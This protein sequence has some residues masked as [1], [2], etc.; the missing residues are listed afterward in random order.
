M[1]IIP[2]HNLACPLDGLPL[3]LKE[4]QLSCDNGHCFDVARQGYTNLLAVQDKRSKHPGDTKEMVDARTKFL[5]TD[6]YKPISDH[7]NALV[8]KD[9][10]GRAQ[11]EAES[12]SILDAGCGEG[13]YLENLRAGLQER[14]GLTECSLIGMDISKPAVQACCKRNKADISWV[15]GTNR[16]PPVLENSLDLIICMFGYPVFDVFKKYLK[17]NGAVILVDT[18]RDHLI[19]LREMIYD[20]VRYNDVTMPKAA[21][22]EGYALA[23]R[24]NIRTQIDKLPSQQIFDL[25]AMTPHYFR[26]KNEHRASLEA[27]SQMDITI[28]VTFQILKVSK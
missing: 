6:A 5:N 1:K 16:K 23:E 3:T 13:Y 20:D 24:S 18:D 25:L 26:M 19:E 10:E 22:A 4:R 17:P 28:D 8:Y 9:I 14:S 11:S 12:Y 7:L 27:V 21:E 15:V 2:A